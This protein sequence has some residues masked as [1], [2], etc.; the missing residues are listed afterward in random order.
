MKENKNLVTTKLEKLMY[1]IGDSGSTMMLMFISSYMTLYYTDSLGLSAAF[2]GSMMLVSRVFDGISDIIAGALIDSTHTRWGKA[3]PWFVLSFLPLTVSFAASFM[4]PASLSETGLKIYTFA[5]YFLVS[6]I[7]FT[8]NNVSYQALLLRISYTSQDRSVISGLRSLLGTIFGTILSVVTPILLPIF[9]GEKN[10]GTWSKMVLLYGS[11][12]T[13]FLA[14]TAF[15]IKEKDIETAQGSDSA[16]A[17]SKPKSRVLDE[18]KILLKNKYFYLLI[19]LV[20]LYFTSTNLGGMSYY[21]ARDVIGNIGY[22]S[23]SGLLGLFPMIVGIMFVPKLFEKFGKR[24][25]MQ[26][27]LVISA[28]SSLAIM[29]N[30]QSMAMNIV[31]M[32]IRAVG[33]LPTI[34]ALG[35]LA[36]D[37]SDYNQMKYGARADGLTT[38]AFCIGVKIGT[39]L[40]AAIVGWMLNFGGYDSTLAVQGP[41][42]IR[43]MVITV[44]VVPAVM[45][46]ISLAALAVWDL[47]NYQSQ[48]QAFLSSHLEKNE[49]ENG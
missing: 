10:P 33:L 12:A 49:N 18:L 41:S 32:L 17:D 37:I 2:A 47:E 24:R 31:F 3:R 36:G 45:Y 21:Y 40:G 27:G 16:E 4:A 11:I 20:L 1:A 6:V 15:G 19:L 39:G 35:T 9:G 7:F 25:S 30:P 14:I 42:A 38:S 28:A 8:L 22:L 34:V 43:A 5:T 46:I 29:I 23:I 48:V 44:A 26:G 13:V